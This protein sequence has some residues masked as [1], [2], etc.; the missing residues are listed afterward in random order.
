MSPNRGLKIDE[1]SSE[2][3]G[4]IAWHGML[5]LDPHVRR[6][7]REIRVKFKVKGDADAA[8]I[9]ELVQKSPVFDTLAYPVRIK[10]EVAKVE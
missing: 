2:P 8:A 6:G 3:E 9:K 5:D 1:I 4:D 10:V 7:Y